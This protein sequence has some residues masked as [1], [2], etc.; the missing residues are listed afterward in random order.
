M[1]SLTTFDSPGI[2]FIKFDEKLRLNNSNLKDL[3]QPI[4]DGTLI[5]EGSNHQYV[6]L[7]NKDKNK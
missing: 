7:G 6:K 5:L 3:I 2:E 1:F 4:I